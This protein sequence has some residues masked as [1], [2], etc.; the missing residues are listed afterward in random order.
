MIYNRNLI[1][2]GTYRDG[3]GNK[4]ID[5]KGYSSIILTCC[6]PSNPQLQKTGPSLLQK[7][8]FRGKMHFS[9]KTT[10]DVNTISNLPTHLLAIKPKL[11]MPLP[12][13]GG[14]PP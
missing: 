4:Q 11:P 9:V 3:Q 2:H 12:P 1:N 10:Q 5:G 7:Y 6:D 13:S 14:P 8:C